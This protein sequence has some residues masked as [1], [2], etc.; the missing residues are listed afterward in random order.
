MSRSSL[1][2]CLL[3]ALVVALPSAASGKVDC[4]DNQ[5]VP[6]PALSIKAAVTRMR[7]L[8]LQNDPAGPGEDGGE[9]R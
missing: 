3:T 6:D 7:V 1:L 2:V 4:E 9:S 5:G 8:E